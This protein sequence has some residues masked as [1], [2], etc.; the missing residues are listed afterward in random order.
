MLV[1]QQKYYILDLISEDKLDEK[2]IKNIFELI[3][4]IDVID[5]TRIE[6]SSSSKNI[7][8]KE[9]LYCMI[10][11]LIKKLIEKYQNIKSIFR[12]YSLSQFNTLIA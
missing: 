6:R 7:D 12:F 4:N 8:Q 3:N 2:F 10:A 1:L 9:R 5:V 11:A